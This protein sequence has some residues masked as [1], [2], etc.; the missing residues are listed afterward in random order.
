MFELND[1]MKIATPQSVNSESGSDVGQG[2]LLPS[3]FFFFIYICLTA[4]Q[5]EISVTLFFR[6]DI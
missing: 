4:V 5:S 6:F 3:F 1:S 2:L